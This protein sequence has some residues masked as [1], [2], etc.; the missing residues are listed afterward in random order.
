MRKRKTRR[1]RR[2]AAQRRA[3]AKM[4]AARWGTRRASPVRRRRRRTM[5]VARVRRH[6]RRNPSP[7]IGNVMGLLTNAATGAAGAIAVNAVYGML[8]LPATL[9]TGNMAHVTKAAIA[10]GLGA[11]VRNRMVSEMV[12]GSLTVTAY[13]VIKGLVGNAIPGLQGMGYYPGGAILPAPMQTALPA[14]T[15]S[16]YVNSGME[17]IDEYLSTY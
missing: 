9:K 13:D 2:T 6:Y 16:E 15:V 8:P 7:R 4:L 10:I 5:S 3:T 12:K 14:P 11:M 1:S 17:G